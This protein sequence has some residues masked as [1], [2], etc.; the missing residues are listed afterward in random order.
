MHLGS[1]KKTLV[2]ACS[3]PPAPR[4]NLVRKKTVFKSDSPDNVGQKTFKK[5]TGLV[6]GRV[7]EHERFTCQLTFRLS[8]GCIAFVLLTTT[9]FQC[10]Q[11]GLR[12]NSR[13]SCKSL[14]FFQS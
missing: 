8:Y 10:G 1:E 14:D 11:M 13:I 3:S 2:Y 12:I 5:F 6:N 7:N 9:V 4:N